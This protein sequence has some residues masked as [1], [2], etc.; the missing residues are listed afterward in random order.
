MFGP[1][2]HGSNKRWVQSNVVP[3]IMLGPKIF[4]GPKKFWFKKFLVQKV[5]GP[6]KILVQ[7]ILVQK[8]FGP[9]QFLEQKN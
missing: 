3:K 4:Q 1:K 2:K 6:K 5:F 9:K 8:N 7:K